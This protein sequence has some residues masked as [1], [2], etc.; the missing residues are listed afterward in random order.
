M[1]KKIII[2]LGS[3]ALVIGGS[4]TLSLK[5]DYLSYDQ[6]YKNLKSV[7]IQNYYEAFSRKHPRS[8]YVNIYDLVDDFEDLLSQSEAIVLVECLKQ[9]QYDNILS[10]YVK[11]KKV[12]KGQ[13]S[14]RFH[15]YE[16]SLINER[17]HQVVMYGPH[18]PLK[19][20]EYYLVC[21]KKSQVKDGFYNMVDTVLS[22]YPLK[23]VSR[24]V[25]K[26]KE[27]VITEVSDLEKYDLIDVKYQQSNTLKRKYRTAMN[28]Y[29]SFRKRLFQKYQVVGELL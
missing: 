8:V 4:I 3:I 17:E 2:L 27:E 1:K 5:M 22:V 6:A 10:A 7:I 11:R 29:Q 21:L 18:V 20:G 15:I 14:E 26:E 28:H 16:S 23:R 12:Y 9:A 13:I 24:H 25:L 19:K